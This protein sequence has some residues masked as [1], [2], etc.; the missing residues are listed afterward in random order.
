MDSHEVYL[1]T[2]WQ[3]IAILKEHTD[4]VIA[5]AISP[6]GR[7]LASASSDKT[8]RLW[9]L[10]NGHLIA[11]P[12]QHPDSVNCLSFSTHGKLLATGCQDNNVYAWDMSAI[13]N[14]LNELL[15]NV[16]LVLI[17]SL[18]HLNVLS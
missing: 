2:T 14:D 8:V 11:S 5:I 18:Y 17:L 9:N 6:N 16:S 3:Q 15:V 12:L 13:G 1:T 7:I 10:E 4:A